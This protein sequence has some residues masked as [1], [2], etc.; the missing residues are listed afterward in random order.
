MNAAAQDID[1]IC[2]GYGLTPV[3]AAQAVSERVWH[4]PTD[5]GDMAVKIYPEG[6]ETRAANEAAVLGHLQTTD[7][8]RCRVQRIQ[9]T[10]GGAVLWKGLGTHALMTRWEAGRFRRY[11]TFTPAEWQAL[12]ASLAALHLGLD[13]LELPAQDTIRSR[14]S[15]IDIAAARR[16][17]IDDINDCSGHADAVPLLAYRDTCLRMI[18]QYAPGSLDAFPADDPQHPIHN[19]YNQFNYLFGDTLPPLILDWEASIGAPREYEL[20]R[21][22]NHLPLESPDLARLFVQAYNEVRPL[23]IEN[24]AW[25]VDAACLQH[26]LKH[27]VLR[28]WRKDPARFGE[29]LQGAMR[30]TSMME[31]KR[32]PLI[33]F[34]YGCLATG[35][36]T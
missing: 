28:A 7:D 15:T 18:D 31:G 36:L 8:P 13:P 12:G 14:L 22:L 35:K 17:L 24:I 32:D 25:A 19:D 6:Q 29:H 11:D 16:E 1:A 9:T 33:H 4:V 30:M 5:L 27:W 20:V 23:R 26:A 10:S 34:F 3:R 21:C 2:L